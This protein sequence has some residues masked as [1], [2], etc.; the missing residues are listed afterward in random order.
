[1]PACQG[2]CASTPQLKLV[3]TLGQ[4]SDTCSWQ[5]KGIYSTAQSSRVLFPLGVSGCLSRISSKAPLGPAHFDIPTS[6]TD[7]SRGAASRH[8]ELLEGDT[9]Q[10]AFVLD[11]TAMLCI[12]RSLRLSLL[13]M[14]VQMIS[15]ASPLNNYMP[16]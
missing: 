16:Y 4:H 15:V 13:T 12:S 10:T 9:V 14:A 7:A 11:N 1:M 8:A 2:L 5:V 3:L 6:L